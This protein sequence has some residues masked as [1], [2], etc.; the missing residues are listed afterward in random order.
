MILLWTVV[1]VNWSWLLIML[2]ETNVTILQDI[3]YTS[4]TIEVMYIMSQIS[5]EPLPNKT[6]G[7][8]EEEFCSVLTI[9]WMELKQSFWFSMVLQR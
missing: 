9:N 5:T 7:N 1:N 2:V 3:P 4:I 6:V 8:L